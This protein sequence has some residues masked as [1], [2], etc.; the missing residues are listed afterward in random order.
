MIPLRVEAA[1]LIQRF[2]VHE[3][4]GWKDPRNSL[5][6][7]FWKL[8]IP[9]LKVVICLRNPLEVAQ[10]LNKRGYSSMAF[11]LNLWL[12]YNQRLLSA[13][14]PEDRVITHY[15]VYFYDPRSELQRVLN[16]L[17]MHISEEALDKA[18]SG[19]SFSLRHHRATLQDLLSAEVPPEVI[20]L[21]MDL[22]AEAGPVCQQMLE[23]E[24]VTDVKTDFPSDSMRRDYYYALQISRLKSQL[25]EKE[26]SMQELQARLAEALTFLNYVLHSK[27]WRLTAPL[28]WAYDLLKALGA[29]LAVG[30]SRIGRVLWQ[31]GLWL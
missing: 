31:R 18:C 30:L 29:S 21:Y 1:K 10:S 2:S 11:G 13:V 28:R 3:P 23:S 6:L 20:K 24:T 7:P 16:M 25:A 14:R 19:I 8:L 15:D 9:D 27:S 4:W 17:N 5:T 26:R 22:C 12:I